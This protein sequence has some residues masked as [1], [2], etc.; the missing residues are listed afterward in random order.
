M[1]KTTIYDF[2][3]FF[4][5]RKEIFNHTLREKLFEFVRSFKSL[6]NLDI[7]KSGKVFSLQVKTVEIHVIFYGWVESD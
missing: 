6:M 1:A 4:L 2:G 3:F 5:E 7:S